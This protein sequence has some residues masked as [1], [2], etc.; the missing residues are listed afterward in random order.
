MSGADP[1]LEST[2]DIR[3][4]IQ[5][6]DLESLPSGALIQSLSVNVKMTVRGG[7]DDPPRLARTGTDAATFHLPHGTVEKMGDTRLRKINAFY[8]GLALSVTDTIGWESDFQHGSL[9]WRFRSR[10]VGV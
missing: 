7:A 9:K 8:G 5:P 1:N 2:M 6:K 10:L 3:Y 4:M